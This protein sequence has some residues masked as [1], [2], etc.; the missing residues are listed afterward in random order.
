MRDAPCSTTTDGQCRRGVARPPRTIYTAEHGARPGPTSH[1]FGEV[2]PCSSATCLVLADQL[3]VALDGRQRLERPHRT[4]RRAVPRPRARCRASVSSPQ[5][6]GSPAEW[7]YSVE[8]P[9]HVGALLAAP[10]CRRVAPA[11]GRF[12][13][14]LGDAFQM[15]DDVIGVFGD[16]TVSGKPVGGDLREA[17]R[18]HCREPSPRPTARNGR[19]RPRVPPISTPTRSPHPAG[20][21]RHRC[22]RR[23]DRPWPARR[24]RRALL[25]SIDITDEARRAGARRLHV[26]RRVSR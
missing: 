15:R 20:H 23:L 25:T 19:A 14:P 4:Q 1:D 10:A 7:K 24:H 3:L 9:L 17:S 26:A 22:A 6:G 8:R 21:R 11:P 13:L 18:R 16:A 5:P 2:S 12:G